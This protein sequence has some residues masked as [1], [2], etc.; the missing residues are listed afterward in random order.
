MMEFLSNIGEMEADFT[1]PHKGRLAGIV[2]LWE[3]DPEAEPGQYRCMFFHDE[4]DISMEEGVRLLMQT[5]KRST[6]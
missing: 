1:F 5:L 6:Q 4:K 3:D 2:V